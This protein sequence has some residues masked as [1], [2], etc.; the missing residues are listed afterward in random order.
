MLIF[1]CVAW[2]DSLYKCHIENMSTLKN[3]D[4]KLLSI[5]GVSMEKRMETQED[6]SLKIVDTEFCRRLK[7]D[8]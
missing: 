4:E 8:F 1:I 2:I 5:K 6:G 3:K 7:L